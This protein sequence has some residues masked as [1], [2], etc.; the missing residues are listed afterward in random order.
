VSVAVVAKVI[1]EN[2]PGRDYGL[3]MDQALA[4]EKIAT[5]GRVLDVLVGPARPTRHCVFL[6]LGVIIWSSCTSELVD[7]KVIRWRA[8]RPGEAHARRLDRTRSEVHF[9]AANSPTPMSGRRTAN[10]LRR[11]CWTWTASSSPRRT[12]SSTVWR[13]TPSA[14][15]A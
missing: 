10:A 6:S 15:A 3:S 8:A 1:E 13:A 9:A 12:R 7:D 11:P 5:S 4:V 2:L 14:R